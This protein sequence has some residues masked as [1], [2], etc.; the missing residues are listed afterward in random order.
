MRQRALPIALRLPTKRQ[1]GKDK[2]KNPKGEKV[3]YKRRRMKFLVRKF[4]RYE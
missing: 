1:G 4:G 3:R 2:T